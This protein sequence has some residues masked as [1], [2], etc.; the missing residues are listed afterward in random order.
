MLPRTPD[1][2]LRSR[3][4]LLPVLV[5][6][7]LAAAPCSESP[8]GIAVGLPNAA[9]LPV[10]IVLAPGTDPADVTVALDGSDVTTSFAPGGRGLVGR[11]RLPA[12][13]EHLLQVDKPLVAV[14]GGNRIR[15]TVGTRFRSP[16][17]ATALLDPAPGAGG[18]VVPRTAWLRL[19][20]G[21]AL[22][23][24]SF[25]GFAFGIECGG[26]PVARSLSRVGDRVVVLNPSPELP[27]GASCRTAWRG[28]S[29]ELQELPFEVAADVAGAPAVALYDRDSRTAIAPFPDDF[30]TVSDVSTPTGL[31]VE[32]DVS[33]F[34]GFLGQVFQSLRNGTVGLDGWSRYA[35]MV[36]PFSH[37]LDPSNLP[38]DELASQDPFSPIVLVD[39]DPASP[40]YGRR[41]PFVLRLRSDLGPGG[42][43][44]HVALVSPGIDLAEGGRYVL[45]VTRRAFASGTPGRP[46]QPSAFFALA[47]H[48]PDPLVRETAAVGRARAHAQEALA[49]LAALP[50]VPI[51][52]EDVALALRIT[53]RTEAGVADDLAWVKEAALAAPPPP[54]TITSA[55]DTQG[56][57]LVVRGTVELPD[58]RDD[59][60]FRINRDPATGKPEATRTNA[61][62][63][64]L[65]LPQQSLDGPVPILM[66]QHGNPG[67]PNEVVSAGLNRYL[68]EAGF[69]IAGMHDTLNR[70]IGQDTVAQT[71]RI[72]VLLALGGEVAAYWFQ[73]H[74]DMIGFLRA[75]QGLGDQDLLPLGAPDGVPEIDTGRLLYHGISEGGNNA[76]S[77]LPFAPELI[78]ATP[79]VGGGRLG[80]T[81]IH[82]SAEEF[83][84]TIPALLPGV[85]PV[86]IWVGLALFQHGYDPQEGHAVAKHLYRQP[87][88]FA[89]LADTTPPHTL[90]TEGIGDSLVPNNATRTAVRELGIPS[91]R[92]L[93]VPAPALT[94]VDAPLLGNLAGGITAGHFQYLPAGTQSCVDRGQL[95]GHYC[96][97]TAP[98]AQTQRL[99]F[100]ET[101][102]SGTAEIV[103]PLP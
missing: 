4:L 11:L 79:T 37:P 69:A 75:L 5:A 59:E 54:L 83:L 80:E 92:R 12:P 23:A 26:A 61:V 77:F 35:P 82:Q 48:D 38:A 95:E 3:A 62:P 78:A 1:T 40:D 7:L 36:L 47:S 71:E 68:D 87:L 55:S 32:L 20:F 102:L 13:G 8:S 44:D 33:G 43:T 41:V 19:E 50:E 64:V 101:A 6:P 16:A 72:F 89:G 39:A 45:A 70:E 91:V 17:A 10:E 76:L 58:Y 84:V 99:H 49:L 97:Q 88:A 85:R 28:P 63:F 60:R 103:D 86:E 65:S 25:D 9:G 98:E 73:T 74:A 42:V 57:A 100:F 27:A 56:R 34:T 14:P 30:W 2:R 51:P 93:V 67:S 96:P 52:P 53:A 29:G 94:P 81:L 18:D 24:A 22:T 46:L 15:T 21:A 66:Y 90:W 31:R